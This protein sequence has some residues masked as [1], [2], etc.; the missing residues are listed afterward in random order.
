M[1]R[2]FKQAFIKG[3]LKRH[4]KRLLNLKWY[5]YKRKK[6]KLLISDIK[7]FPDEL[8]TYLFEYFPTSASEI[9]KSINDW[10]SLEQAMMNLQARKKYEIGNGKSYFKLLNA[11]LTLWDFKNNILNK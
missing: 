10:A 8:V 2:E 11:Q 5:Q 3:L 6:E 4:F 9:E 1:K 7:Y